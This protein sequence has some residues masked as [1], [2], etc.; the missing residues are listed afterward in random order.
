MGANS[1][2]DKICFLAKNLDMEK[3]KD[4]AAYILKAL[5]PGVS[6]HKTL[7]QPRRVPPC[8]ARGDR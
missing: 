2:L 5:N 1:A 4:Y 3:G 7:P 8:G 6:W